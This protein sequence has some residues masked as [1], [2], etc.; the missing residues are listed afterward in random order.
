VILDLARMTWTFLWLSLI[1]VGGGLGVIPELER[2]VVDRFHWVTAREFLDG[3]TLSQLTPGPTMLV[4]VF[5]GYRAHGV[6]GAFLA[7]AAMFFPTA[8][9]T[10]VITRHWALLRD[11]PWA[12]ACERGLAPIG[13][14]LMAAGVYTLART[15]IHDWATG[16]L[17]LL[18]GAVL[19]TGW[20]PPFLLVLGA[21]VVGW[22]MRL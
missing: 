6:L 11:R 21:G 12:R 2:Q 19:L 14:G 16:S 1:C 7:T 13:I 8:L 3:Y 4:S 10:A 22:L 9:I 18:T 15:G 17:A 5:V 20:L